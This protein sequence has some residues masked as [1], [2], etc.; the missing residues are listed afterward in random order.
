MSEQELRIIAPTAIVGYG[1]QE[2]SLERV[3]QK[4]PHLIAC[5]GGS[6]DPGP[7]YLGMGKAF[8]GRDA[9]KRD[10][11]LMLH[12]AVDRKI[13]MIV[14]TSGGAGGDAH[15]QWTREIVEEIARENNLHFKMALIHAEQSKEY[16]AKKLED[17]RVEPIW[18][19]GALDPG[20]VA[21]STNIVGMAGAEPYIEALG[22]GAQVILC[23]RSDDAA[24]F[25]AMPIKEEFDPALGWVAGKLLECGAACAVPRQKYGSE[26]ITV[27]VRE[28]H[29]LVE[30]NH[31]GLTCTPLSVSTFFLHENETP[32][33]HTEPSGVLDLTA[34]DC[35]AVDERTVKITGAQFHPRE[36]YTIRLEGVELVGYRCIC[37]SYTRDPV[38]VQSIDGYLDAVRKLVVSRVDGMG[39][40]AEDYKLVFRVIGKN[41]VMGEREPVKEI[42]THELGIIMEAVASTQ[43]LANEILG[44]ARQA[45][46]NLHY[47]GKLCDEGCITYP[48]SPSDIP[49]G[50]VYEYN[51]LHAVEPDSP[52]EMFPVEY[53]TV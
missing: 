26:G 31:P 18:P 30:P 23:G 17:G 39:V 20:A 36:K 50:P 22:G 46:K 2:S 48:Y 28:D 45:G 21:R 16:V 32:L 33:Y 9:A 43:E 52:L 13:P 10:L 29:I 42:L 15:L 3:L 53:V 44:L 11:S 8:V 12:A 40:P 41:A 6:T 24:I 27:T 49:A 25:A 51:M 1:F 37:V 5:D 19:L 38:L 7:N 35:Q 14:G 47:E 4:D 34:L